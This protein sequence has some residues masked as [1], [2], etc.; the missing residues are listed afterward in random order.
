MTHRGL[1]TGLLVLLSWGVS[2]ACAT[3]SEVKLPPGFAIPWN[4]GPKDSTV[5]QE[6][7][8]MK[9][10]WCRLEI[11]LKSTRMHVE[12]HKGTERMKKVVGDGRHGGVTKDSAN[13]DHPIRITPL[14]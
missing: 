14:R 11:A 10:L 2:L 8:V 6:F 12:R 3:A 9:Y 1:L 4:I 13:T 7:V 5:E